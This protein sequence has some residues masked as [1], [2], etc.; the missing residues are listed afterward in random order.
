MGVGEKCLFSSKILTKLRFTLPL[1][2]GQCRPTSKSPQKREF[3]VDSGASMHMSKK[4]L[5]SEELETLWRSRIF[6]TVVTA[7][8]D[9]QT[10]EE[11]QVYVDDLDLFMT[12]QLLEDTP[13]VL[14]L[15]NLCEQHG[16]TYE[17]ASG[18]KPHLTKLGKRIL[19]KTE[20][21]RTSLLSWDC[22]QI[23]VPPRLLH[24]DRRTHQ[25]RLQVQQ[26]SEVTMEHQENWRDTPKTQNNNKKRD[27]DGALQD[28]DCETFQEWSRGGSQK[29]AKIQKC[30][31]PHTFLRT[32]DSERPTKVVS[33]SR[34]HSIYTH[35]PKDRN[36]RNLLANQHNNGSLQKSHWRSS[37][38]SR[39]FWWLDDSRSQSPQWGRWTSKQSPIRS[40]GAR[41]SHSVDSHPCKKQKI[42]SGDGKELL[43]K[44]LEPW[45]K[46]KV[47]DTDSSVEFGKSCADL[48]WNHRTSTPH[49]SETNGIPGR[50]VG[51]IKGGN[52]CCTVAMGLGWKNGGPTPWSATA[53]CRM[54]KTSWQD[55]KNSFWK[56]I[57]RNHR[58]WGD[59]E[60]HLKTQG[61]LSEQW[62]NVIQV[63]HETS[64]GSTKLAGQ[65]YLEDSSD[66]R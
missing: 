43:R 42:F 8:G 63:V 31:R 60:N 21:V 16:Y 5:S 41:S 19:C 47:T 28:T 20:N 53:I 13:A 24:R 40:R 32:H 15:G 30:L 14:S 17:R 1:M 29:I 61:F 64:Q 37:A 58:L 35:F 46:P 65:F 4:D 66:T 48:S 45:Q 3:V 7:S 9:V 38:S 12:V 44:C 2:P 27:N 18:Q 59:S 49:G 10:N 57:R 54:F 22:R 52:F 34:K 23:L 25:A 51:R 26:Q 11:A 56:A 39:K 36:C 33:K 55:G 62:L 50:A 6:R